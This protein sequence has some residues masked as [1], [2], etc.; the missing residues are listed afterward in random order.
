[1]KQ[2][3]TYKFLH[4]GDA[5]EGEDQHDLSCRTIKEYS[6]QTVYAFN[7]LAE[8]S[9]EKGKPHNPSLIARI[10]AILTML[11]YDADPKV[12]IT[13]GIFQIGILLKRSRFLTTKHTNNQLLQ[14][15]ENS[16]KERDVRKRSPSPT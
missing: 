15:V 13:M 14:E 8:L 6:K 2:Q 11:E 5:V 3:V 12:D 4:V 16:T 9:F 10:R 1:M 7:K